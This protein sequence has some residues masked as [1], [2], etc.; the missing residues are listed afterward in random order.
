LKKYSNPVE[1]LLQRASIGDEELALRLG[2]SKHQAWIE[3]R[4]DLMACAPYLI[5]RA[6][7][8]VN[9]K[10]ATRLELVIG[11]LDEPETVIEAN[12]D[13]ISADDDSADDVEIAPHR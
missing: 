3:Q 6:P 10:P 8:A 7:V 4:S 12:Y 2:I 13:E 1:T 5:S 9:I 11:T